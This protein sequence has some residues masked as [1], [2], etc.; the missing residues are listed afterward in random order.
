[1]DKD[2]YIL[3]HFL[4]HEFEPLEWM[5]ILT[6]L[7]VCVKE[8]TL[9]KFYDEETYDLVLVM[10]VKKNCEEEGDSKD[11]LRGWT[12]R[13]EGPSRSN[14]HKLGWNRLWNSKTKE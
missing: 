7:D 4:E 5:I 3:E 2:A 13:R 10:I 11:N 14:L 8:V 12:R 9:I 1:M 6:T